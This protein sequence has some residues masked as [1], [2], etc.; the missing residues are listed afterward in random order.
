MNCPSCNR[1]LYSRQ[2]KTCGF[3]GAT[4]PPE[5]L[6]SE[7]EIA[8]IKA[9]QAALD[10]T[11]D[12]MDLPAMMQKLML[13]MLVSFVLYL[14]F[15]AY[16][17]ARI[18]N[19]FYNST[20]L[21]GHRFISSIRAR[22]IAW[23]YASNLI[24]ISITFGLMIPWAKIRLARYRASKLLLQPLGSLDGFAQAQLE[25]VNA[26]GEELGDVFDLDIGI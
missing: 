2:R 3:C 7:D 8:A 18:W 17:Q 21:A 5:V 20:Q 12:E 19:L 13:M 11:D 24:V 15:I 4:L 22:D 16:I 14:A 25:K 9:E 26:L 6:L 1:L 10:A 23:L